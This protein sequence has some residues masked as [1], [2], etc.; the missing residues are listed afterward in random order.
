M[1]HINYPAQGEIDILENIHEESHTLETLHTTPGCTVAGNQGATR[2][3]GSQTSY[4]CDDSA[5]TG[6]FGTSQSP[7]QGCAAVNDDPSSYGTPFNAQGGGVF[8]VEWTSDHIKIWNWA[9]SSIPQDI[10]LGQPNPES[11]KLP[12]F[13]TV[14]GTCDIDRHFKDHRII[15]D[16]TFCGYWAGQSY[17]WQKTSC[18]KNDP[19]RFPTCVDYVASNP[20]VFSDAYWAINSVRVYQ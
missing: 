20:S 4:N 6:P 16:T 12:V 18:Y 15:F 17:F 13:T 19:T 14:G 2:Q 3:T 1:S 7:S 11:W 5:A 9:R 10:A 8:A